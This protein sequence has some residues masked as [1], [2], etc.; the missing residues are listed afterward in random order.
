MTHPPRKTATR[1]AGLIGL[2][3]AGGIA[4]SRMA[5]PH[6]V[7]LPQALAGT[8]GETTG[9]A[10][11]IA[12]YAGGTGR[13]L[14]LLHSINAAASAYEVK[15][16]FDHFAARRTVIAPDLPGFGFSD[17]SDRVYDVRLYVDAVHDLLDVVARDHGE[18]PID[19]I[20]VSLASEFAARAATERPE[21][22]RSLTLVT[23]TGFM[24]GSDRVAP[25][26][27]EIPG[28][29]RA[30]SFPLWGQALFDGLVS[31]ASVRYFLQRTYGSK[32]IDEDLFEY[33][34]QTA[35]R[36]GARFAPLAF[37]S[38]RLFSRDIR[39][40]YER[41]RLP[42]WVPHATRG[43]FRD[44]SGAGWTAAR[45]NWRFEP[46][47]TGALVHFED[48]TGFMASCERFL[49]GGAAVEPSRDAGATA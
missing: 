15:P 49:A 34:W 35:H 8:L 10:G 38:G 20:A 26:T 36:P 28:L 44:F 43:D 18:A 24:R 48:R 19:V 17:R 4:W 40:V 7:P 32:A 14:L 16:I 13:P 41:L 22:F 29:H 3:A 5:V 9:R 2:A 31:R 47:A 42:V 45:D 25:G 30:V 1:A 33:C 37:L 46:F 23:P 21:R 12:Y 27:R 6:D 39:A 11:R